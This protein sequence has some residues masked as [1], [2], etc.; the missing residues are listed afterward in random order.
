MNAHLVQI[1]TQYKHKKSPCKSSSIYTALVYFPL[2][3]FTLLHGF[4]PTPWIQAIRH[5]LISR[6][7]SSHLRYERHPGH[8]SDNIYWQLGVWY[9]CCSLEVEFCFN[10]TSKSLSCMFMMR[11]HWHIRLEHL[12]FSNFSV[13]PI[14]NLIE[15]NILFCTNKT[16]INGTTIT[17]FSQ[18]N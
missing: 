12:P 7:F 5:C 10:V 18:L 2:H 13:D 6:V 3:G 15:T 4:T 1:K 11:T 8:P 17:T 9:R 14:I 16:N